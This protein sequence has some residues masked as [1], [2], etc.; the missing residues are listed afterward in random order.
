MNLIPIEKSLYIR[1][2]DSNVVKIGKLTQ[3]LKFWQYYM[4]ALSLR[5]E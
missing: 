5:S 2:R 3:F 4:C 1:I